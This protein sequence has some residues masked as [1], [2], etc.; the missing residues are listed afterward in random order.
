MSLYTSLQ[1]PGLYYFTLQTTQYLSLLKKGKKKKNTSEIASSNS[2]AEPA[3]WSRQM[4][5]VLLL[6]LGGAVCQLLYLTPSHDNVPCIIYSMTQLPASAGVSVCTCGAA[7]AELGAYSTGW[8]TI[9][10]KWHPVA[11]Q[12]TLFR[13]RT[14]NLLI[15]QWAQFSPF[16]IQHTH[17]HT[18]THA[19]H[20]SLPP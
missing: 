19:A 15:I 11:V 20:P 8:L 3:R 1:F 16:H 17:A 9:K 7:D 14:I 4:C 10:L 6:P 2:D 18:D 13:T 5:C 12:A